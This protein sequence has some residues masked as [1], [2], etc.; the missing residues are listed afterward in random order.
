MEDK[1][2]GIN[3]N[4]MLCNCCCDTS[5]LAKTIMYNRILHISTTFV[6]F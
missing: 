2:Q 6:P 5:V 4:S 1:D 3:G